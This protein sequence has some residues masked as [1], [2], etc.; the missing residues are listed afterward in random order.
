[1]NEFESIV[2]TV[3]LPEH[4]LTKGDVGTVVHIHEGGAAYIVEFIT[5]GGDTVAVT[6]LTSK[7]VRPALATE[8]PHVRALVS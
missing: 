7:Q 5:Y 6:T 4:Q 3:D 8:L 2:L 1:M